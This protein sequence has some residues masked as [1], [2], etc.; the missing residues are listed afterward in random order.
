MKQP[1]TPKQED[2]EDALVQLLHYHIPDREGIPMVMN[3]VR[4][5]VSTER[6]RTIKAVIKWLHE[7][8]GDHLDTYTLTEDV[9]YDLDLEER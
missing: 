5:L 6:K 7:E 1:P 8:H 9:L 3:H 2:W 4:D